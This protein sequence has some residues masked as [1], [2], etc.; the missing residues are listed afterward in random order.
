MEEKKEG[1][2]P[3]SVKLELKN[4]Y[5]DYSMSVIVGRALPDVRDGLKPCHRRILY[6]M[7]DLGLVHNKPYKKSAR[8]VGE[9]L[10]K[11]HPHGDTAVYE[12]LVRMVQDFSLRYPLVDGQG[13][14][15]S[16]DGDNA[17]A[18]RYTEV[19]MKSSAEVLLDDLDKNTVD[20]KANFDESLEE[21]IVLPAR[22]PNLLVNGSSGIAVGMATNIPPH[23]L[24][25]VVDG[26]KLVIDNPE[27]TIEE[28]M[29]I[30]KGPDFPTGGIILG[31]SEIRRMYQTGRGLLK[32]R[33]IF[34]V[35]EYANGRQALIITE[36]PYTVNKANLLENIAALVQD[37]KITGVSDL[38]DESDRTGMR[39]V[40]ELK[41]NEIPQVVINQIFKHTSLERTFGAIL[42]ALDRGYPKL[43][44][45]KQMIVCYI[46]HRKEVVIRR[47]KFDLN[48]A[49][50]RAHILEGF[51]IALD[52]IDQI[53]KLIK[54]AK[55]RA[56]ARAKLMEIF[57]LSERQ[58]N[59][60][61]EMRLYQ[62]TGLEKNKIDEEY[63]SLLKMIENYQSILN[64]DQQVL[65][66]IKE[67]LDTVRSK[68][69]DDR[70]TQIVPSDSELN[71]EDLIPD[72]KVVITVSHE[73]Y[74]KRVPID[75]YKQ[76]KR[77]GKGVIGLD[78]KDADFVEHLFVGTAHDYILLFSSLGKV[79][80]LKVYNVPSAT[81]LSRGKA[82]VNLL[83]ISQGEKITAMI[84]VRAFNQEQA[85]IMA[86]KK[87]TVKKTNL[88][89]FSNPRKGGIIAINIDEGD[90]LINVGL[91]NKGNDILLV[92]NKGMSIRFP[93]K[94][95]RE[96]GRA[97]RG[98][99]GI[100]LK[101]DDLVVD[102]EIIEREED[103]LL[104][105]SENGYGKRTYFSQYRTQGR[106]GKGIITMKTTERNGKVVSGKIITDEYDLM[107]I[108]TSGKMVRTPGKGISVIGRNTQGVRIIALE[109][110]D[111]LSSIARIAIDEANDTIVA[112]T[113]DSS[114]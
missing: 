48:N 13:N 86:T 68:F 23:N 72:E 62:L 27:V 94:Q 103:T 100:T 65:N 61:L 1:I 77:G 57:N 76:Q 45:L 9:V 114:D 60:I 36:I 35:E 51:R 50:N 19:K 98:V 66:I 112:E 2:L 69:G 5:L 91:V 43:M 33:G 7:K 81:R 83:P 101:D 92:T 75:T 63:A 56:V 74:I 14:F 8:V 89:A 84:C 11:Y 70:K 39:V 55:D 41:R 73:G 37:K 111:S 102:M 88:S 21:P 108:T 59:A 12:A 40:I 82:I 104:I 95:A 25:E 90:E 15:G 20:F 113:I 53:V 18:M 26:I 10:G 44:N 106:G 79:Y 38:R 54:E 78:M 32:T 31:V 96:M 64:D 16:V 93:E 67:E 29:K 47:T 71:I 85:L 109:K 24:S 30:I 3:I 52:N 42:V 34:T 99:K 49:E 4:S 58:A 80:W 107:L 97:T 105:I 28:L 87:G 17:A 46:E 22:I 110:G 6:A